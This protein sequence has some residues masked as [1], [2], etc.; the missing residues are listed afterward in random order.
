MDGV[1]G[2]HPAVTMAPSAE[3]LKA[4]PEPRDNPRASAELC[5]YFSP[6]TEKF[7]CEAQTCM[8]NTD[9]FAV[10]CG[11]TRD[12]K[13][14]T[15]CCGYDPRYD[16]ETTFTWDSFTMTCGSAYR[17]HE[18]LSMV[19]YCGET[20]PYCGTFCFENG[21]TAYYCT[22]EPASLTRS[23]IFT[24]T[25][26]TA[27]RS[28]LPRFTGSNGPDTMS[29]VIPVTRGGGIAAEITTTP[30]SSIIAGSV[31]AGFAFGALMTVLGLVLMRYFSKRSVAPPVH[32]SHQYSAVSPPPDPTG[33][34]EVEGNA[35]PLVDHPHYS[36]ILPTSLR[37]ANTSMMTIN[38]SPYLSNAN[39]SL[40][41]T[42]PRHP[43]YV[44]ARCSPIPGS[45]EKLT[46]AESATLSAS[47]DS[48]ST[49]EGDTTV[50]GLSHPAQPA[51]VPYLLQGQSQHESEDQ[52]R[53]RTRTRW[54]RQLR[55]FGPE[56]EEN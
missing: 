9:Y 42:D 49:E 21:Y 43:Q 31:L 13:W 24:S 25:G 32:D 27:A 4:A 38:N 15:Q 50:T 17:V 30:T 26:E 22:W 12:Y 8:F 54:H 47:A 11:I 45:G 51:Y 20:A 5:G 10:A 53:G 37:T 7:V 6:G 44:L 28:G 2:A 39:A 19:L 18:E 14:I 41:V 46:S 52:E 3:S 23:V 29:T 55:E 33:P 48:K 34:A 16:P 56:E 1:D 40:L 35:G 36:A